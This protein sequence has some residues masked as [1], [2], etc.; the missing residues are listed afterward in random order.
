MYFH[1]EFLHALEFLK[2]HIATMVGGKYFFKLLRDRALPRSWR[3]SGQGFPPTHPSGSHIS[4]FGF[5]FH[6][7]HFRT[8]GC[9][10]RME[11]MRDFS[12]PLQDVF[13]IAISK[14]HHLTG[15]NHK[16]SYSHKLGMHVPAMHPLVDMYLRQHVQ[17]LPTDTPRRCILSDIR[18]DLMKYLRSTTAIPCGFP[19]AGPDYDFS[20]KHHTA[21]KDVR[22]N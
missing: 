6:C 9:L 22:I 16:G 13:V 21:K 19:V 11:I 3:Y 12:V 15:C 8:S 7:D 2:P 18:T 1:M 4:K 5:G 14:G 20:N 10:V 17:N